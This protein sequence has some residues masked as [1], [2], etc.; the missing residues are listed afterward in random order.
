MIQ[1]IRSLGP[2]LL[3]AGAAVGVSHLVQ[4]TRAGASYGFDLLWVLVAAHVIKYPFFEF[5][6]R[7]AASTG[8]SLIEAYRKMGKWAI[9]SY[10]LLTFLTMFGISAAI[11]MVTAGLFAVLT[12]IQIPM[13]WVAFLMMMGSMALLLIGRF[14]ALE[15]IIKFI[16]I[17]LSISTVAAV[18]SAAHIPIAQDISFDW[19]E[20]IDL[21]FVI[22]FVGWLPAPID[23]SV[24]HSTWST[25]K[26][27]EENANTNGRLKT[28]LRDFNIGYIGTG[29]LA[30]GFLSLGAFVMYGQGAEFASG[31]VGFAH[32]LIDMYTQG[33]G[34]WAYWVI[35]IA[36]LTTMISTSLTVM[37]AYPRVL[38]PATEYLWTS[39]SHKRFWKKYAYPLLMAI[40]V[41]GS[42]SLLLWFN[43]SM[44]FMVDLATTISFVTAPVLAIL[45][46]KAVNSQ[47]CTHKPA[48]WL[49]IYALIGIVF[50]SAFSL[51]YIVWKILN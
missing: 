39:L 4:S 10:W 13:V 12:G 15:G 1:L 34:Q 26:Q 23:V 5:A 19:G 47:H 46:Y 6:P 29:F 33:L 51:F 16:I 20:W 24:W 43:K 40:V 14:A 32:Q 38:Q 11:S 42:M 25:A 50:L 27:A 44:K 49:N 41:I 30:L 17:L 2:G 3:Y 8:T 48:K 18:V 35:G 9:A 21:A 31:G 36:A 45:N 7:Y 28:A 37:D 22:A